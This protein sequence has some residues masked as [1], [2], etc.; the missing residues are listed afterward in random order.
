MGLLK[1]LILLKVLILYKIWKISK[2]IDK[3][4]RQLPPST[5]PEIRDDIDE[6]WEGKN[7]EGENEEENLPYTTKTP[8]TAEEI[9]E[10]LNTNY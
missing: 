3:L 7:K 6:W 10:W 1:L 8:E 2:Q 9:E 4:Q 5:T